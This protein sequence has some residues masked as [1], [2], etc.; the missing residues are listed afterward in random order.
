MSTRGLG[1]EPTKGKCLS[2]GKVGL[3][4]LSLLLLIRLDIRLGHLLVTWS[5]LMIHGS[6]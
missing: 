5:S 4:D 3:A 1:C 2:R 6:V